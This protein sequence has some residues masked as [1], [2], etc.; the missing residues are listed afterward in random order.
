MGFTI[1]RVSGG[2]SAARATDGTIA[3]VRATA[4]VIVIALTIGATGS[5]SAQGNHAAPDTSTA[6][7]L[8][9]IEDREAIRS[10]LIAYGRHFDAREFE[11]YAGLFAEDSVWIGSGSDQ[12]YEGPDQIRGMAE[13]G[14]PPETFPGSYHVM[15]SIDVQLTG[16]D[17]ATAWSRWTFVLRG[18]D[19][20]PQPFRAGHYEDQLVRVNGEWKFS[21]RQVFAE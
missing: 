21:F 6:Q 9:R 16:E 4:A 10:L 7:A 20:T 12:R 8:Q 3:T 2:V 1:N 5:V 19:G 15:T 18:D 13:Q 17:T 11:A 14:F